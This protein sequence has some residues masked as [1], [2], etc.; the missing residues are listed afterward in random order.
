MT[1]SPLLGFPGGSAVKNSPANARDAGL[2]PGTGRSSREENG[3]PL[4]YSCLRDPTDGEAWRTAVHGV[5]K[6]SETTT[7]ISFESESESR[8]VVSE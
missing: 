8:S 2:I 3:N 4:Q 6:E 5:I 1:V 7:T